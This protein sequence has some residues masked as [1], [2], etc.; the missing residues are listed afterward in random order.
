MLV[1]ILRK[2]LVKEKYIDFELDINSEIKVDL[3][4]RSFMINFFYVVI[5]KVC[6]KYF[7]RKAKAGSI[8]SSI[9]Q[10]VEPLIKKVSAHCEYNY[11]LLLKSLKTQYFME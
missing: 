6:S 3:I 1:Q 11:S 10:V 7:K 5:E 4:G 2:I 8:V 9:E